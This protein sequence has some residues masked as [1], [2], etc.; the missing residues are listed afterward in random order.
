MPLHLYNTLS[1]KVEPFEP[2]ADNTVRMYNCG[3]TVYDFAHIGNF[4]TFIAIDILR[5]W[6]RVSGYGLKHVMNITDVDDRIIANSAKLGI[7]VRQYTE[8]FENLFLEDC[9]ILSIERPEAIARA[10][11]HMDEMADFIDGLLQQ[12]VAYRTEDGSYY[13]RIT[14]FPEYG[15]L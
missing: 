9:A 3:P 4:R 6:L 12:G 15:K 7:G 5:R 10:T 13:F 1:G 14:K 8:K 11:E 2:L